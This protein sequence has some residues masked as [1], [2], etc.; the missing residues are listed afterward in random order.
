MPN[1]EEKYKAAHDAHSLYDKLSLAVVSGMIITAGGAFSIAYN[2]TYG[3]VSYLV[4][5]CATPILIVLQIIYGRLALF[6]GVARS[7]AAAIEK[8]GE[9]AD[10]ISTVFIDEKLFELHK[11]PKGVTF[12][13]VLFLTS[14]L[15]AGMIIAAFLTYLANT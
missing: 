8:D 9:A 4:F 3:A 6:A 2:D 1:I 13:S 11:R 7:V 10:G 15:C 5:L 12:I 14:A